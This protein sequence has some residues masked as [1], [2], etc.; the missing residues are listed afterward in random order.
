MKILLLVLG[1]Y[2]IGSFSSSFILGKMIRDLDIREHGSGNAGA[3]NA[4]RVMGVRIA[5]IT[6]IMDAFK[7]FLAIQL[8]RYLIG[9]DGAL[10]A[11]VFVVIGHNYPVFL[12]FK[13]GKGIATSLGLIFTLNWKVALICLLVW[14]VITL[15]TRYVSLASILGVVTAPIALNLLYSPVDLKMNLT[16]MFLVISAV[17]RHKE[18]ISRLLKGTESKIF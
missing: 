11:S 7:G 8:G 16:I 1:S 6:F 18:N 10:L 12:N 5:A 9:F 14:I 13:G 17:V 15:T 3:T 4:L 2:L